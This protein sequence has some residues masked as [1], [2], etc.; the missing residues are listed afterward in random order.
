MNNLSKDNKG[1]TEADENGFEKSDIIPEENGEVAAADALETIGKLKEKL[2]EAEARKQEYLDGWQRT[3]AEFVNARKKDEER[4]SEFIAF[5]NERLVNELL[6]VL[7]SFNMAFANKD[8]WNA[9]AKEWRIG[10]EYIYNQFISILKAHNVEEIEP[11]IG[12]K[13]DPAKHQ[14][15][16]SIRVENKEADHTIAEVLQ[17]GY[18]LPNRVLRP[19]RVKI[20]VCE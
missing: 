11:A 12:E 9:V 15:V 7:D 16:E 10:V 4:R 20:R 2:K 18:A 19:A 1:D 3:Q 6:T 5:A 14:S 8:A 13:F 17:K